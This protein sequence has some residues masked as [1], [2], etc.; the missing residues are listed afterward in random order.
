MFATRPMKECILLDLDDVIYAVSPAAPEAFIDAV[1]ERYRLGQAVLS[2]PD[3]Y[4]LP[5]FNEFGAFDTERSHW[6]DAHTCWN[7]RCSGIVRTVD[8]P[9]SRSTH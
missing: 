6:Y 3:G 7:I 1:Q 4:T 5:Y 2:K 8:G 9:F